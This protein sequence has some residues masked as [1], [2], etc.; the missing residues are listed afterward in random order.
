MESMEWIVNKDIERMY[1]GT[2]AT[3]YGVNDGVYVMN[4]PGPEHQST[5]RD[6]KYFL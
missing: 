2:L 1:Y 5:D 6:G 4:A 3:F